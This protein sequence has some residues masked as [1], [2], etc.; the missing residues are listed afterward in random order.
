MTSFG[1][2]HDVMFTSLNLFLWRH[3]EITSD[4]LFSKFLYG[5]LPNEWIIF[6]VKYQANIKC[7]DGKF[8]LKDT[9]ESV[10]R[11]SRDVMQTTKNY[12][13]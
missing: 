13:T 11:H 8:K 10:K 9:K 6:N 4:L 1:V 3:L 7:G 2:L 12:S 5:R